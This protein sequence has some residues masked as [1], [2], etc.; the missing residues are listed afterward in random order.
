MSNVKITLTAD[1]RQMIKSLK[2]AE[3]A[4]VQSKKM[5]TGPMDG[6]AKAAVSAQRALGALGLGFA[7][8]AGASSLIRAADAV[9]SLNNRL[10]LA[11]RDA[12]E[13]QSAYE[14]LFSIAQRSR[15][16][17]TDLGETY[18]AMAR[19]TQH[20]GISQARLLSVT[21]SIGNAMA[22]SGGSAESMKAALVQLG[23]GLASGQLRGEELNS[24]M[25][26]TPRL[27]KALADGLGIGIGALRQVAKEG[28]LTSDVV[29][30]ALE[31]QYG[32]L[33]KE[34]SESTVTVGQ[35]MTI[36][37]NS[38]VNAAGNISDATN[39]SGSMA[40]AVVALGKGLDDVSIVLQAI[41]EETQKTKKEFSAFSVISDT[42]RVAFE[43]TT[44][45]FLNVKFVIQ[46]L[47]REIGK[48]GAQL[49]ALATL[50]FSGFNEI[51]RAASADSANARTELDRLTAA[52]LNAKKMQ[53]IAAKGA[54]QDEPR[55]SRMLKPTPIASVK[56]TASA[57]EKELAKKKKAQEDFDKYISEFENA[58]HAANAQRNKE[59]LDELE[60]QK[61]AEQEHADWLLGLEDQQ[62]K[63]INE[64]KMTALEKT[65]QQQ[66]DAYAGISVREDATNV[67]GSQIEGA[68]R[69]G[70]AIMSISRIQEESAE[71]YRANLALNSEDLEEFGRRQQEIALASAHSQLGAF[72]SMAG[73]LKSYAK[74]GSKTYKALEAVE[75]TY[76][77]AQMALS[78]KS[79]I[80]EVTANKAKASSSAV[81]AVANQGTGDPYTAFP[82][83]AAMIA[84]MAGLGLMAGKSGK[85]GNFAP[86]NKGTGTVF[87]DSEAQSESIKNSIEYLNN[88]QDTAL[89]Y[90]RGMLQSL[91]N[92]ENSMGGLTNLYLRSTGGSALAGSVQTGKSLTDAGKA[93]TFINDGAF[94]GAPN[95]STGIVNKI[96]GSLFSKKVSITGQG[97]S[98]GAQSL[99]NVLGGGFQ[100]QNYVDVFTKK[101][102]L[103]FTTST[104]SGTQYSALDQTLED[105]F[106]AIFR[107]IGESVTLASEVFGMDANEISKKLSN[108]VVSIGRIDLQGLSGSQIEERLTAVFGAQAD[109]ISRAII[110][111][112]ERLQKV[113][114]GYFQTLIRMAGQLELVSVWTERLGARFAATGINAAI[115]AD[116]LIN[117]FGG[118]SEF[119]EAVGNF[120]KDFYTEEERT[121]QG[122]Q[123]LTKVFERMGLTLPETMEAYKALVLSQDLTTESGREMYAELLQ[124][125]PT[126]AEVAKKVKDSFKSIGDS[127]TNEINRIR[128]VVVGRDSRGFEYLQ[129]Q[130]AI[131]TAQ[132]RAGDQDAAKQLP[133]ISRAMLEMAGT[134]AKTLADLQRIQGLTATS[135]VETRAILAERFGLTIPAFAAGGMHGG[136]LRLV[137]ENGPEL[138]A[139]GPSR[140]YNA[141]QTAAMLGGG[142]DTA[143]EMRAM[144]EELSMLRAEARAIATHTNKTAKILDRVTPDG[145]SLQ[146]SEVPA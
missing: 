39:A 43:A 35:S 53:D 56:S 122:I 104:S 9:T 44:V 81:A 69:F 55:F 49:A 25:E 105:Q 85:G 97:I 22:V 120:Y 42:V 6:I 127:I 12:K 73:G 51:A 100:G 20:L 99:G 3:A 50:N 38:F 76:R 58:H 79:M 54:G 125:A 91:R 88:I 67:F 95:F 66:Q 139:T 98:A 106:T 108:Y 23:Q 52:I 33:K 46:E 126:F 124:I 21:E 83:I 41:T 87:G 119:N 4:L 48:T 70:D 109:N 27:A 94:G 34:V 102:T 16:S 5:A 30:R 118:Q 64:K 10:K 61:K 86:T 130:F 138:E 18:A 24:V 28:K 59:K 90:S 78:I 113:G 8:F 77:L 129:S 133:E 40:Q 60:E 131:M 45:L 29:I 75:K 117:I 47:G 141:Q 112:F 116:D 36:L 15:V 123:E 19:N 71:A 96:I 93:L 128:G 146:V 121:A 140:I 135:L 37:N 17:F 145:N 80:V 7:G 1:N 92:I 13:A 111:G 32:V 62:A 57:D 82:R 68:L 14:G 137:G 89:I 142:G 101:K 134:N 31:S 72:A 11:S 132:A 144:R 136:G 103:G 143:S 114:E 84:I 2:E 63:A 74:Q 65:M 107:N 110:P 115:F 26:Q